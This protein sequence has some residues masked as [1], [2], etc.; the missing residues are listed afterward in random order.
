MVSLP[1][2]RAMAELPGAELPL[3]LHSPASPRSPRVSPVGW[4]A[5]HPPWCCRAM[6]V[7]LVPSEGPQHPEMSSGWTEST[8]GACLKQTK[9]CLCHA[10][11][12]TDQSCAYAV[13]KLVFSW[14]NWAGWWLRKMYQVSGSGHRPTFV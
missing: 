5:P 14:R 4:G 10:E 12:R 8:T 3:S 2:R 9:G 11:C 13:L 7:A 6:G 1:H